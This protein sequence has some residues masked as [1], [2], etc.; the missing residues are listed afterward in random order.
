MN[1]TWNR[2]ALKLHEQITG[3]RILARLEELNRTQWLSRDE[4]CALQHAK[5]V[6]LLEYAYQY[7]PYYRRTFDEVGFRPDDVRR[8]PLNLRRLPLL[9]KAI[10]RKNRNE[11][12]TTSQERRH[13]M[14]KLSTS[15]STGQPLI[16]LQDSDFR[17]AV[18]ADIQRHIG[19]GGWK[20]GES[21]AVIWGTSL[22]P[23][24][25]ERLRAQLIDWVW[26]RFQIN[27]FEMTDKT[28]AELAEHVCRKKTKILF[29]Y[30][31]SLHRFAR[32]IRQSH[33]QGITFNGI[34]SSAELLL[35]LVREFIENTF[36]CKVFDRYGT[37]DLGG[38]ACECDAHTGLHISVENNY[39]EIHRSGCPAEPGETGELIVTN[40][41]NLGMPFIRYCIEDAGAWYVGE[42][43]PCG[44]KA[45][46]L[47]ALDGRI[48]DSF[49]TRNG[50]TAWAG[51]SG[52]A[53]RCLAHPAIKQFQIVQKALDKMIVRLIK[54]REIPRS[55]LDE[56]SRTIQATFGD[57]I[58]VEFEFVDE[59]PPLP[60]GKHQ[61]AVSE[62][63]G[64]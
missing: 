59:I 9:T 41:N 30:A 10:I 5:L 47:K 37:L 28:M 60:S 11:L 56:I 3:R 18:T 55:V 45:P 38:V 15:G 33:F 24:L 51:F 2:E 22:S 6:R 4:L 25:S 53:F 26:N 48:G 40:L 19:W 58:T 52:A 39:V 62:I 36:Q 46:R 35:P 43:C 21:Q 57:G 13:R 17:D 12:L 29:G 54:E 50:H 63:T 44:R 8:D 64:S 31:T 61:Y 20:L 34:Y 49:K 14:S 23:S 7:V 1:G 42:D 27:A 16:F 32:F